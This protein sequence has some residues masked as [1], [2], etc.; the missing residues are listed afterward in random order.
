MGENREGKKQ[1]GN[2]IAFEGIDGS[3]KSTQIGLLAERL[4]K[5]G[6]CCYTTMEPTNA[7]VGSLVRQVMTGRI[8]MDNKAIAALFAADRLD[9]LLNE[10]DGIASKI[11][12]G[13]TVLTDRYY[14]SSYAY[15]SVDVP[16][17]WVIR[18]NEQSALILRPTVNL[19]IDVDPDTAL[20]R[21]ARNRFHQELFEKKSR[22]VEVRE[23]YKKAFDLLAG[24][25]KYTV[26]DGNQSREAIAD[27]IWE[28]V[29]GYFGL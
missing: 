8:R 26:I 20:E 6:V 23:N 14:F 22:L 25:E 5:E 24:E 13:T 16:M 2:F 29:R 4:K 21:I 9:H 7:P 17:E 1:K 11:E 18:A 15:H 27:N 12:E 19:F 3:G 28:A 10:V